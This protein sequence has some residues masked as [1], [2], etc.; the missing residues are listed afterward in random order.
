MF[1]S[2]KNVHQ[3]TL[4]ISNLF[5]N[6]KFIFKRILKSRLFDG[7]YSSQLIKHFYTLIIHFRYITQNHY[8]TSFNNIF[9]NQIMCSFQVVD[10]GIQQCLS[11]RVYIQGLPK[12]QVYPSSITLYRGDSLQI[13]CLSPGSDHQQSTLGYS[14]T[15]NG[16]LFQSDLESEMWEDLYPDG[17]LLKIYNIQVSNL[18]Y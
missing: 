8:Y 3:T 15:K 17:S 12:I 6:W 5:Y 13:R 18:I 4:N 1:Y 16:A 14:W 7:F 9:L 10:W 11:T 2:K